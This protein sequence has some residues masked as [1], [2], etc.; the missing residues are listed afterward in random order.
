LCYF[1]TNITIMKKPF[2]FFMLLIVLAAL[3]SESLYPRKMP[4][5]TPHMSWSE[6]WSKL[7]ERQLN[8]RQE[9]DVLSVTGKALPTTAIKLKIQRGGL[10]LHRCVIRFEDGE[11]VS[12]DMRNDIPPGGESRVISLGDRARIIV[13]VE[14][15]YDTRN[16]PTTQP[17]LELWARS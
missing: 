6:N 4:A 8:G 13:A 9:N 1:F 12:V 7:A 14:F 11:K 5:R 10:N 3:P 16:Y 17:E 15:W 2:T